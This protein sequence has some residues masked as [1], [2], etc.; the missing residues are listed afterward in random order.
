MKKYYKRLEAL[1]F[2]LLI[3]VILNENF[4]LDT[5]VTGAIVSVVVLIITNKLIGMN[6]ADEFY[7]PPYGM[8]LYFLKLF[9]EIYKAGI[10][11]VKRI[12]TG[13]IHPTFVEYECSLITEDLSTTL[14]SRTVTNVPGTI[15]YEQVGNK[16]YIVAAEKD[17]QS[18]IDDT[19]DW[20]KTLE[21]L[22]RDR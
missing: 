21:K 15:A 12:F 7:E 3:W 11:I 8:F 13:N 10:D 16:I 2:F 6:Y 14:L 1:L 17:V 19:L 22:E 20:E 9:K 4:R 18:T 5:L